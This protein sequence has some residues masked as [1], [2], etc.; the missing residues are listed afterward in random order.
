MSDAIQVVCAAGAAIGTSTWLHYHFSLARELRTARRET[1]RFP[2][3]AARDRLV[4]LVATGQIAEHNP[5]WQRAYKAVNVLVSLDQRLHLWDFISKYVRYLERMETDREFRHAREAETLEDKQ[6]AK[7]VPEYGEVQVAMGRALRH[8]VNVRTSAW[9]RATM[10]ILLQFLAVFVVGIRAG[11]K[12]AHSVNRNMRDM[13][14]T[15]I[16]GWSAMDGC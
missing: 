12:V 13:S 3:F 2:M 5:S 15:D 9:H 10:W 11:A 8:M 6:L 16:G 14:R 1:S 4:A 7:D